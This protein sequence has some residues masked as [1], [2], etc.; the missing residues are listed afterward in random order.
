M[1]LVFLYGT[2]L[3]PAVLA[4]QAGRR[5]LGRRMVP[6]R[7]PGWRRVVLRG[8]PYPTLVRARPAVT[9]GALL[10]LGPRAMARLHAYEGSLYRLRPV[11]PLASRGPVAARAWLAPARLADAARP[12]VPIP[13]A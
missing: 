12:W 1:T 9:E 3:D 13:P 5:G 10:S 11:R 2:L 4:R 6:A 7:L 8:T